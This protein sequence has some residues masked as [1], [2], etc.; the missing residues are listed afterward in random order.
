MRN[1]KTTLRKIIRALGISDEGGAIAETALTAPFLML[2]VYGSVEFARV[3][4]A[5]IEVTNAARAGVSYGAQNGL[6]A[7]DTAGITW[8]AKND[9]GNLP[10]LSVY[11]VALSYTCSDGSAA[12][13]T[14]VACATGRLE[15]SLTVQTSVSIDPM[16]HIA[17]LPTTYALFGTAIQKCYQ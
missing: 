9:G 8:A 2:L 3:A 15:E 14:P 12:T 1:G 13:G 5:A 4:Y 17:G 10:G 11:N 6:T 7:S 16:V